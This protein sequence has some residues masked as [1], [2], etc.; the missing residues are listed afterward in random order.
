MSAQA[1]NSDDS[2]GDERL[3]IEETEEQIESQKFG[4]DERRVDVVDEGNIVDAVERERGEN[5]SKGRGR[6]AITGVVLLLVIGAAAVV[7]GWYVFGNGPK[8]KAKVPVSSH[9]SAESD[10]AKTKQAIEEANAG[11]GITLS[12]GS[13]VRP[14]LPSASPSAAAPGGNVPVTEIN[15]DLSNTVDPANSRATNETNEKSSE[16]QGSVKAS[17][18]GRNT[19]RSVRISEES[20]AESVRDAEARGAR[21]REER[22]DTDSVTVPP[23]G[24]MLPVRSLGVLYTLRSG[25]LV[26]FELTRDLN[27][28]G[29]TMRRGTTLIGALRGAEFDRAYV[30]LVGFIDSESGRFV[31]ISGD[32]LGSDGATGIRGKR[33]KMSGGWSRALSK[34]GEAG[35]NIAGAFAGSIGRR[36]IVINDALGS[37]GGRMTSELDGVLVGRD[38]NSFVEVAAGSSGY[39]MITELPDSVKG[40]DALSRLSSDEMEERSNVDQPR[41]TTGISEHE[42]AQLIQSGDHEQ[43]RSAMPRMT[44]EMRRIA[45]AVINGDFAAR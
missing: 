34:L 35:L 37:Y 5:Q 11:P 38:R 10:E 29:W 21:V 31:K 28:K 44:P 12:D 9:V 32:L 22:E 23:F 33:R 15:G 39:M 42:L 27:G 7:G 1:T 24:S 43:I 40:V 19:E 26:R 17:S 6:K 45:E 14:G 3:L 25:G 20:N 41:K 18:L 4:S 30:S 36:P 16:D 13:I 8:R 2:P